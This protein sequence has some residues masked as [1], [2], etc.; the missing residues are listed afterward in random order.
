MTKPNI[1]Y[2]Q[3]NSNKDKTVNITKNKIE[4]PMNDTVKSIDHTINAIN[5]ISP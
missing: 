4:S 2:I 5:I 1:K 3:T